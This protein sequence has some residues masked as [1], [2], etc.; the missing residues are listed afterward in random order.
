[1]ILKPFD[2]WKN[3]ICTCPTKL[4]LNPY[5]GC[6]HGCLYCYASSYI[7]RFSECRPKKDLLRH[8]QR[9]VS[10]IEHGTL[11]A[12]SGSTDPYQPIEKDLELTSDCLRILQSSDMAVQIATKSD[13]VCRDLELLSKMKSVINITITTLNDSLSKKLEPGAPSPC[14][15]L[16][17]IRKLRDNEI[18]VSVRVDPI[19][20]GIN[21]LELNS[22]IS[23][24]YNAGAQ[25]ITS[26]TYKAKPDSMK[27]LYKTFPIEAEALR[28]LLKN[29][30]RIG[31]S[32]Y[33]PI[34]LRKRIMYDIE[35]K[36]IENGMSF[37]SCREGLKKP[38]KV[39]CDGSHLIRSI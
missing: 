15:R 30:E 39:S 27:R 33:L 23:E 25:H 10:R 22:I 17:A 5:T 28:N 26:S 38:L 7:P 31:G 11:I 19:I 6:L 9:D 29:G 32:L 12:I 24:A 36:A 2:P 16:Q 35:A 3:P 8:L 1:M 4:S 34:E 20:P 37:A 14:K 13:L 18:P 21:D